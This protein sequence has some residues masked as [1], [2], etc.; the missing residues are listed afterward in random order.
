MKN[1]YTILFLFICFSANAP[2]HIGVKRGI[3]IPNL[4]GN[5]EQSKGYTSRQD[6]YGR[7]VSELSI[8]QVTIT[9]TRNEKFCL[10]VINEN[11][12]NR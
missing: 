4:E 2:I 12:C 3:S 8:N 6:I 1:I 5:S 11:E 7:F 10:S 9:A